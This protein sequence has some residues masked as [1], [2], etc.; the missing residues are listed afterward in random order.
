MRR[1]LAHPLMSVVGACVVAIA[2][3]SIVPSAMAAV[4]PVCVLPFKQFRLP[5]ESMLPTLRVGDIFTSYCFLQA[6]PGSVVSFEEIHFET[7][8]PSVDRGDV[9]VLEKP[10]DASHVA[11]VKRVIGL[12][13]DVV[14][15][16][17]GVIILN[18]VPVSQERI[19]DFTIEERAN[20]PRT[21][22]RFRETLPNGRNYEVLELAVDGPLDNTGTYVVPSDHLFVL[23]DNRDN[24]IDSRMGMFGYIP[25]DL[26]VAKVTLVLIPG[27][28]PMHERMFWRVR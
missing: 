6:M 21:A 2:A 16:V 11:Y 12:P 8:S 3:M 18:G 4:A 15:L 25:V 14:Q 17:G 22:P 10:G 23:G 5:S 26:L 20:G 13:G 28:S 24:S 1:L 9:V 7:L 19:G 27:S